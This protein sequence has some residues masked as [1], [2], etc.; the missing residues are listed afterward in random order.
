MKARILFVVAVLLSAL[1]LPARAAGA[2]TVTTTGTITN[3]YDATGIWGVTNSL[4]GWGY[5]LAITANV[6]PADW[7]FFSPD[8]AFRADILSGFGGAFISTITIN[9]KTSSIYSTS[10]RGGA[11]LIASAVSQD[12]IGHPFDWISTSQYTGETGPSIVS[13]SNSIQSTNVA[14]VPS[15]NFGQTIALTDVSSSDFEKLASFNMP[16]FYFYGVPAT[17]SVT[18]SDY[19][20]AIPEPETYAMLLAGLGLVGAMAWRREQ[21]LSA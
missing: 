17:F 12:G 14:F 20:S 7:Q 8:A 10:T 3:G 11:Q 2:W 5:T 18:P 6:S 9:G 15:N 16:N 19:V 13:A 1:T 21:V 4:A